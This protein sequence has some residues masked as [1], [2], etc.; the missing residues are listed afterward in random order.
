MVVSGIWGRAM[1]TAMLWLFLLEA[2]VKTICTRFRI[3]MD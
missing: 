3:L 1:F 2:A